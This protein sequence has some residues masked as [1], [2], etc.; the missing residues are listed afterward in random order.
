[1]AA[2]L[3]TVLK[4][5]NVISLFRF[6]PLLIKLVSKWIVGHDLSRQ[7]HSSPTLPECCLSL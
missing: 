5:L 6:Y 3:I 1:M 4:S 2:S 7:I